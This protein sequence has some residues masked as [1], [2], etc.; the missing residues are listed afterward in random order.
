MARKGNKRRRNKRKKMTNRSVFFISLLVSIAVFA[1][2]G[3]YIL[4]WLEKSGFN[5]DRI[6]I[7][8][9]D[10]EL[11]I[12][13]ENEG[14]NNNETL[15]IA[16]FG[17]DESDDGS[18]S[19]R[20][21]SIMIAS[22]DKRHKKI[23]LTSVMRDTYVEIENIGMDKIGHA[24]VFGGPELAIKTLNQNFN[25]D[26]R[27]FVSIDFNG[28][29]KIIDKI[30]GVEIDVKPN[31]VPYSKVSEP[32]LQTLN[33]KQALAY[34]R[35]R[36]TGNGDYE[37]TERQRRVMEKMLNK[38]MDLS[39]TKYPGLLTETLPYVETSFTKMEILN[40]GTKVVASGIK[41]IEQYRI[42]VD[43]HLDHQ[44]INGI[45]YMIPRDINDNI[46]LLKKFIYEDIK[47]ERVTNNYE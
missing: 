40:L 43:E 27:D 25:M 9:D 44:I 10:D 47:E 5:K 21:D 28:F 1:T 15:N 31:E 42:P 34:S 19:S 7:T 36:K 46:I 13:D 6:D 22:I 23:K 20:S 41:D 14:F 11:G 35:I 8:Q 45:F 4:N 24:Y 3:F 30:G 37:R 18:D 26:I 17:L 39:V 2:S 32:G 33:G 12:S 16:L 29:E 38:V